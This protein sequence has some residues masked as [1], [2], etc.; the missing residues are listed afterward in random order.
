MTP[1]LGAPLYGV[2]SMIFVYHFEGNEE[3]GPAAGRLLQAAEEGRCRLVCSVISLLEVLVVPKRRGREDL[4][5]VYREMFESFPHLSMVPVDTGIA[6]IASDLRA[7]QNLRTPDAIH[8]AT[9][10]QA[11]AE[12]FVSQDDR[13]RNLPLR[14]LRVLPLGLLVKVLQQR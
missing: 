4:C 9:A 12:A 5:Q 11:G 10:L 1:E 14:D 2:D 6:E 7:T 8:L 13:F 3:F